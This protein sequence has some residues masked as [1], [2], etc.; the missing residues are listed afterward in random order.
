M[1][2][3]ALALAAVFLVGLIVPAVAEVRI[4][5]IGASQTYGSGRGSTNGGVSPA[6]AFPAQ[7]EALLRARGIDA[8]VSNEGVAGDTTA[9]MLS[10]LNGG[11]PEGTDVVI[12]Q[13][14]TNDGSPAM[15]GTTAGN[16]AEMRR[17][18]AARHIPV[19][20]LTQSLRIAPKDARD[21]D[22]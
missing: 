2:H 4:V 6:Q 18:L 11:V 17:R 10:R 15:R 14:G 5:A 8:H 1:P 12:L 9:G 21:P 7:L 22:G 20:M 13:P 16:I 19:I 3:I